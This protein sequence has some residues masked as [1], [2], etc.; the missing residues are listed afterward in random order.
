MLVKAPAFTAL[1]VVILGLGIGVNTAIFS[2][3]ERLLVRRLPVPAADEIVAQPND[4]PL[5][6]S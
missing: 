4:S 6:G 3:F 2:I 5:L 1:V